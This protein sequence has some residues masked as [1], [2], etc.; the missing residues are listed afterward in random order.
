MKKIW[1]NRVFRT[2]IETVLA[3]IFAYFAT[4]NIFETDNKAVIGLLISA[5]STGIA[6]ILPLFEESDDYDK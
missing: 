6:K 2:F 5:I 1:N 4:T 3:T